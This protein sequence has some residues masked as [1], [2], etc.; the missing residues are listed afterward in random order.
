MTAKTP[1]YGLEYPIQGE[2]IRT[3]RLALEN[4]AKTI[5]AALQSKG[6][7]PPNATDLLAVAARVSTLEAAYVPPAAL[8]LTTSATAFGQSFAGAR[9]WRQGRTVFTTGLVKLAAGLAAQANVNVAAIPLALRPS[10][11]GG[12][13][14]TNVMTNGLYANHL[15]WYP[16]G[17]VHLVNDQTATAMAAGWWFPLN[18]TWNLD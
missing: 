3:T 11:A 18:C 9:I 6:V 13:I 10:T 15:E 5:E 16:S 12:I 2:P 17:E 7:A 4:N 14:L 1:L 8:P